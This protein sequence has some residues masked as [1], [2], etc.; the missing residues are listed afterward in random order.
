MPEQFFTSN[1]PL[2]AL[3]LYANDLW[4]LVQFV[5]KDFVVGRLI[6]TYTLRGNEVTRYFEDFRKEATAIGELRRLKLMIQEPEA[7]GIN[8]VVVV[9]LDCFA[10]NQVRVQGINESWVVGK[11]EAIA[12]SLR[13]FEKSMLTTYKK[14]GLTL[15]QLIFLGM[16]VAIPAIQSLWQRGVFVLIVVGLLSLFYWLHSKII[17]NAAIY[18]G[19][20]APT[21]WHRIW[22]SVISWL[23][24][25]TASFAAAYVFYLL[26]QAAP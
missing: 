14:F 6:V 13:P 11:A 21:L 26:T 18:L 2:G 3:R 15:N 5:R 10:Q 25:A 17:P 24:A 8:K 1:I 7:Y 9:E 12:R 19:E 20:N 22:P 4:E 23:A 16:L